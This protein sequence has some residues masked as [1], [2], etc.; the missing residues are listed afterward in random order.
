MRIVKLSD[1]SEED[2]KKIQERQTLL[3]GLNGK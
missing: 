3:V 2:K 1:L